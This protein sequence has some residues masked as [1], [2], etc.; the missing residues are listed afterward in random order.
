M[1]RVIAWR[2]GTILPT[3][4]GVTFVV[5]LALHLIPG[6]PAQILLYG[7]TATPSDVAR[8]DR[9]LGLNRPLL[10]QYGTYLWGLLHGN[11][12]YSYVTNT[13]VASDVMAYLPDTAILTLGGMTVAIILGL[14]LGFLAGVR[15]DG[16]MDRLAMFLAV[17][18]TAVPY[19]WLALL[20]VLVFAVHLRLLPAVGGGG[21]RGLLLPSLS[22][23]I[24]YAA[25]LT[26]LLRNKTIE[27]AETPYV[28]VARAKGIS[29]RTVL[30]RHVVRNT[31]S[32]VLSVVALQIASMIAGAVT[33][34]IVFGRPGLGSLLLQSITDKD[35]PVV[36]G[37]CL[38]IGI[39]YVLL[40]LGADILELWLDPRIRSAT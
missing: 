20:L 34:E 25:V 4:L 1:G 23:G 11:L 21:L 2:L 29:P 13:P 8:L 9:Q 30:L 35:I 32:S 16:L 26:R 38:I 15:R 10:E 18:G 36:Q 7:T 6:N 28:L 5:F 24:G 31:I 12:G 14:P 27:V 3:L 39:A 22:L 19:F 37:I 33:I 17:I 40:N